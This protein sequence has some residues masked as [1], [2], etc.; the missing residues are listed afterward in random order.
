[1]SMLG[2]SARHCSA[3]GGFREQRT[4]A[5]QSR[6]AS[7]LAQPPCVSA[8]PHARRLHWAPALAAPL[9]A[10]HLALLGRPPGADAHAPAPA[11][12]ALLPDLAEQARGAGAAGA[13]GRRAAAKAAFLLGVLQR[14]CGGGPGPAGAGGP[15]EPRAGPGDRAA[16]WAALAPL[17][18]PS[19]AAP[20]VPPGADN[21]AQASLPAQSRSARWRQPCAL[22]PR[23][24][25]HAGRLEG[26]AAA[27][28]ALAPAHPVPAA[29]A[30]GTIV[31][32]LPRAALAAAGFSAAA[33]QLWL[34]A[35]ALL[36]RLSERP[37]AAPGGSGVGGGGGGG[38]DPSAALPLALADP[39]APPAADPMRLAAGVAA[40]EPAPVAVRE[41]AL[42][43]VA[44]LAA[45]AR[46]D[47]GEGGGEVVRDKGDEGV[48]D[49]EDAQRLGVG[50]VL[51]AAV[52]GSARVRAA[53]G[54]AAA[55]L[56]P[57]LSRSEAAC[58]ADGQ[59]GPPAEP[60]VR[61]LRPHA[62]SLKS[63]ATVCRR[64]EW[65]CSAAS[66]GLHCRR[67]SRGT[68]EQGPALAA[69]VL[70]RQSD[71]DDAARAA[72]ATAAAA[73]APHLAWLASGLGGQLEARPGLLKRAAGARARGLRRR[74]RV[75]HERQTART[76]LRRHRQARLRML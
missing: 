54:R 21:R 18:E 57:L 35:L 51:G 42:A 12:A 32:A 55:A 7:V 71:P 20:F 75:T 39:D 52:A 44:A 14:F 66:A 65:M 68:R 76:R 30:P 27:R 69:V 73:L 53:A 49:D 50:A 1:V 13:C 37:G 29:V 4:D 11:L 56:A 34:Q 19:G 47:E 6:A 8:R 33:P 38:G 64:A 36:R 10:A 46:D 26:R 2:G 22:L 40:H 23:T 70:D 16:V 58:S 24:W 48:R 15:P 9:A 5:G 63:R 31:H 72:W 28:Q 25:R 45:R 60:R 74:V 67:L 62:P 59:V 43:W 41:A 17:C 3:A 61:C